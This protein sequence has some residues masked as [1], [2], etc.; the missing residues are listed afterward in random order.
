MSSGTRRHGPR[1]GS[2]RPRHG[3]APLS[4]PRFLD[5]GPSIRGRLGRAPPSPRK[6]SAP[7]LACSST[8]RAGSAGRE[9]WL[10]SCWSSLVWHRQKPSA[11]CARRGRAPSRRRSRRVRAAVEC[12]SLSSWPPS[13]RLSPGRGAGVR[14]RQYALALSRKQLSTLCV[15]RE[16]IDRAVGNL[17]AWVSLSSAWRPQYSPQT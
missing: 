8:A 17:R 13:P 14:E 3:M 12:A 11:R 9:P 15:L 16:K 6:G 4:D 7:V 1:H 5:A 2:P 10:R